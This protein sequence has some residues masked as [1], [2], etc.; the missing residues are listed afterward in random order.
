MNMGRKTIQVD[1]KNGTVNFPEFDSDD[2]LVYDLFDSLGSDK[3]AETFRAMLHI[4]ALAMMED[5]ISHL[6]NSTEKEIFPQLERFKLHFERRKTQFEETAQ[7]KGDIAED[8]IVDVLNQ[9]ASDNKWTD[10]IVKSGAIKGN[11]S[12]AKGP[13]KT[14]DVLA[15]IEFTANDSTT[16]LDTTTVGIEVKFEKSFTIGDPEEFSV[17]TGKAMDKG[18]KASDKKTAWSQLLETKAN[19]DSP[20]SIIVFDDKLVS[21]KLRNE[22][23]DVS[24]LPGIPGFMVIIDSQSGNFSNLLVTYKIAREMAIHHTRGNLDVDAGVIE[25]IAKRIIHYLGDAEKV[26]KKVKA[27]ADAAIKMNKEV[28]QLLQHAIS[29]AEYTEEFLQRYLTNKKLTAVDYAEFYFA[30]PVAEKLRETNSAEDAFA[31]EQKK[32]L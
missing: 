10:N 5:R 14:G 18:F 8:D 20:F 3:Y 17:E 30:H 4:G 22:I 28:Q 7:K 9:Y 13:N 25:L 15:T 16:G 24:Y 32:L 19:R 26:S 31:K 2:A 29:H 23:G 11:L 27:H 21:P 12:S 6:I 1:K